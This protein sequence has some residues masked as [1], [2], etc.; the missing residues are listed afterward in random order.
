MTNTG[1]WIKIAPEERHLYSLTVKTKTS[2][3]GAAS[4]REQPSMRLLTELVA[5]YPTV[6]L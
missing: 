5:F 2:S 1:R 3:V 6:V 4:G